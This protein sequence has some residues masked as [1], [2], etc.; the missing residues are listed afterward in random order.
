[1]PPRR[2]RDAGH[3]ARGL[4]GSAAV[5]TLACSA[6]HAQAPAVNLPQIDIIA[7]SPLLGSGIDRDTVPAQTNVLKGN[8]LTRGGTT[9]MPDAVRALNEQVGG[10][11]L[12]S[13][14]GN[15][16]QPTLV[17]HGFQA[18]A[19]QGTQIGRAHV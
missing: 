9:P 2:A 7:P 3:T 10:V 12:E 5:L 14:S 8:D 4:A 18:S 16:Y 15:P 19:L 13:A 17:Y 1:M 11:S 6:A